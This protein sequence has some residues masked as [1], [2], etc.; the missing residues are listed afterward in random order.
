M[1]G[2]MTELGRW[3]EAEEFYREAADTF[4]RVRGAEHPSTLVCLQGVCFPLSRQGRYAEAG[5]I[6]RRILDTRR[7]VL[8]PEHLD[9]LRTVL[10]LGSNPRSGT[11][12]RG[13]ASSARDAR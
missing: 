11:P 5:E 4:A 13:G 7:K 10:R 12:W 6:L 2:L 9:T 1:G 8:G 3:S